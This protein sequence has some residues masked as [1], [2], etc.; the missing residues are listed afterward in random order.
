MLFGRLSGEPSVL[1]SEGGGGGRVGARF[2]LPGLLVRQPS[3]LASDWFEEEGLGWV[4]EGDGGQLVG[5]R[6]I[7][8]GE[9]SSV[10]ASDGVED[11]EEGLL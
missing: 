1:A 6:F 10:L 3:V 2:T 9:G 5:A 4:G 7:L 11:G 8:R